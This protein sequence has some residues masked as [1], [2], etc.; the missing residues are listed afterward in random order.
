MSTKRLWAIL[1]FHYC[2]FK[3]ARIKNT[4]SEWFDKEISEKL[5]IGHKLFKN[6]KSS[7]FNRGKFAQ[8]QEMTSKEAKKQF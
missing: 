7:C 1:H 8:R 3:A 5:S 6:F 4:S 2:T